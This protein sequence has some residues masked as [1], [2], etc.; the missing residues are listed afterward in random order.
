LRDEPIRMR[1]A[2][3]VIANAAAAVAI[4]LLLA[5]LAGRIVLIST[6]TPA[7]HAQALLQP[8]PP[9][10]RDPAQLLLVVD[11]EDYDGSARAAQRVQQLHPGQRLAVQR[12]AWNTPRQ[13]SR[14]ARTALLIRS[15]GY[16]EL[17]ILLTLSRE[18][19]VVRVRSFPKTE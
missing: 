17:P 15:Y 4:G 16:S 2:P 11:R 1:R 19:Q 13:R 6:A 10:A 3:E 7:L 5:V 18:G 8:L 12:I 9:A 14:D